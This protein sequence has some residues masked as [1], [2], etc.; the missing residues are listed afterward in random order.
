MLRG[1]GSEG[2]GLIH[3]LTKECVFTLNVDSYYFFILS[4]LFPLTN[5]RLSLDLIYLVTWWVEI[6]YEFK[7]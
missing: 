3:V 6:S 7:T 2:G 1:V 4:I 5:H